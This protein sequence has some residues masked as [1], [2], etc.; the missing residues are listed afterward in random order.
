M[1][2][3]IVR[4]YCHLVVI[5]CFQINIKINN[6]RFLLSCKMFTV[7]NSPDFFDVVLLFIGAL[8]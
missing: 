4:L 1:H 8:I 7:C 2:Q 5:F 3:E 6:F